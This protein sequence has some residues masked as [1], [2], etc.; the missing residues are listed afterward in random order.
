MFDLLE[1]PPE[2]T[3]PE[4]LIE[5]LDSL[6]THRDRYDARIATV[7]QQIQETEA[8]NRDGYTSLTAMLKHSI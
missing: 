3:A 5:E 8:F 4:D 2:L 7:L 6:F 1:A